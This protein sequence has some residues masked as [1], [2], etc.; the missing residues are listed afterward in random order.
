MRAGNGKGGGRDRL[1]IAGR[2]GILSAGG[3]ITGAD[4][5]APFRQGGLSMPG[6]QADGGGKMGAVGPARFGQGVIEEGAQERLDLFIGCI[7]H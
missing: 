7:R 4:C 5:R 6:D 2:V 1:V 3:D